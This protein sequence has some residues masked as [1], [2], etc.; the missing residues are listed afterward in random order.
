VGQSRRW[1]FGQA[2]RATWSGCGYDERDAG[3][4]PEDSASLGVRIAKSA[5]ATAEESRHGAT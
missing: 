4:P 5:T 2:S 1:H 3:R